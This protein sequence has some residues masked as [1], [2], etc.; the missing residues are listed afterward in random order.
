MFIGTGSFMIR[1]KRNFITPNKI[2]LGLTLMFSL[3][4]DS[5]VNHLGERKPRLDEDEMEKLT[6]SEVIT[7]Q[8]D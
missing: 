4:E 2:E 7:E 8:T 5:I 3:H 6:N 1:G